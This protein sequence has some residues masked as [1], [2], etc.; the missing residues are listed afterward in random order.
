MASAEPD[1]LACAAGVLALSTWARQWDT[2]PRLSL[3]GAG[4]SAIS[5]SVA[6]ARHGYGEQHTYEDDRLVLSLDDA[7]EL[8]TVLNYLI[9]TADKG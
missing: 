2:R 8:V 3:R 5:R 4:P 7:R 6:H 1:G 9:E